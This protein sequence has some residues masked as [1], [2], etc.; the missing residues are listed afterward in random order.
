MHPLKLRSVKSAAVNMPLK[1]DWQSVYAHGHSSARVLLGGEAAQTF[2][3]PYLMCSL[4]APTP[5]HA[6]MYR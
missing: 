3:C 1:H 5:F 4:D 2:P 6:V